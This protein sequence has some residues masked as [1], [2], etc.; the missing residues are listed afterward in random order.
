MRHK[1]RVASNVRLTPRAACMACGRLR[2]VHHFRRGSNVCVDC[3]PPRPV[4]A[5]RPAESEGVTLPLGGDRCL[6]VCICGR[7][8]VVTQGFEVAR[9]ET[10]GIAPLSRVHIPLA[11]L[12]ALL[13]TLQSVTPA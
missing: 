5:P 3:A 9:L 13:A 8:L 4:V 7:E 12:P 6:R 2:C 11:R 10:P 1:K